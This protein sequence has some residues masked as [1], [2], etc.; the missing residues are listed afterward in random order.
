[1]QLNHVIA[2]GCGVVLKL[3]GS[4]SLL[5]CVQVIM[6]LINNWNDTGGVGEV[7]SWNGLSTHEDFFTDPGARRTYRNT[8]KAVLS[9]AVA[10][11]SHLSS[12]S[13]VAR[14]QDPADHAQECPGCSDPCS[15]PAAGSK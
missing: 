5:P 11:C 4:V 14:T 13:A 12:A 15:G 9:C 8:V 1:M 2:H 7:L 10:V 6:P 3:P